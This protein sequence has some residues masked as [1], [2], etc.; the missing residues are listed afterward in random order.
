MIN[1]DKLRILIIVL[2][3]T[4]N[5]SQSQEINWVTL[6]EVAETYEENPKPIFVLWTADWCKPCLKFKPILK[7]KADILNTNFYPVKFKVNSNWDNVRDDVNQIPLVRFY[8][9][10]DNEFK[11]LEEFTDSYNEQ[12][13][14]DILSRISVGS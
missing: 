4:F 7:S 13:T 12:N 2:L 5:L 11:Y 9:F 8:Y 10:K 1:T 14:T 6:D 3:L